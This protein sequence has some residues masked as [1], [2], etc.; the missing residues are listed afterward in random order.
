MCDS[1][2]AEAVMG[3]HEYNAI[4][5]HSKDNN[6]NFF[7]EHSAKNVGQH[8]ITLDQFFYYS[9]EWKEYL[10]WF[11][12]LPL[13]FEHEYF[14]VVHACWDN[15]HIEWLKNNYNGFSQN[16]LSQ[17]VD[18]TGADGVYNVIE[19]TLKGKE[20]KLPDGLFFL[21]KD[22]T[23]REECRVK[24]WA[25]PDKRE[26]LGQVF[27]EC[28]KEIENEPTDTIYHNYTDSKPVFFGHY[29]LKGSPLT[30]N[31]NAICLDYSV[32]KGGVLVACRLEKENGVLKTEFVY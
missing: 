26:N 9:I 15:V 28:P 32:A 22:G 13:F 25:Q 11:K 24:W 7:R 27:I 2:N 10:E 21:D 16:F 18:R 12:T 29:W 5:F 1:G 3:N 8:S 4:C 17:A 19:E 6:G 31:E 14:R 23:K 30:E 20:A